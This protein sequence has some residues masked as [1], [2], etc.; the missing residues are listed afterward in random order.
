MTE[1]LIVLSLILL[2]GLFA[3]S[4]LAVVSARRPR[5]QAMANSGRRGAQS[6]LALSAD[7]GRF[8]SAVQIGITLIGIING[9]YSGE[10][11]GENASAYLQELGFSTAVAD[12][13]G[14]G[15]VIATIT[16]LSVIVGELVPKTLALRNSEAIAC[17]VAPI[18]TAF[19]S[20]AAPVVWLL[21]SST[22]VVFRVLGLSRERE[23]RVTDEEIKTLISEAETAGVLESGE[24]ELISGVMRLAD[25][26]VIGLMTPRTD[27]DWID[28]DASEADMKERL[29][30]T[31]HSRLPVGEG[32]TDKLI[33]VVQTRELLAGLLAGKPFEVAAYIRKAPMIPETTSALDVLSVLRNAE[34]PMALIHDEYG[35]F[36]GLV[37]PADILEAIAGVFKSDAEGYEPHAVERDDGSWLLSGSMPVDEM[38]DKI[39]TELPENRS[40]ETV[41]GFVLAKLQ[42][43]PKTGEHADINGWRFEVV[44]LDG[45]RIDKVL[46]SRLTQ[47]RRRAP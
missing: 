6:A 43:I 21:D 15:I 38:A 7:P 27:V 2:N 25:R 28:I 29:I 9:A 11:F 35:E 24:G 10:T 39:G 4:E 47:T 36:E 44:D 26:A 12:P 30:S 5:L 42:H 22:Q 13:V 19:A 18:M 3:L 8:L 31:P 45:R 23:S 32:S 16:Y 46:A 41:A 1:L 37:T 14:F 20:A 34:V 33:G 17:V 40:Y